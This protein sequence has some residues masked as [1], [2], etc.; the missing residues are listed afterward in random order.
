MVS[1]SSDRLSNKKIAI[2]GNLAGVAND[3]VAGLRAAGIHADLFIHQSDVE[4]TLSDPIARDPIRIE[5][6]FP[7][8]G[9]LTPLNG[10]SAWKIQIMRQFRFQPVR[11]LFG[12]D[13]LHVHSGILNASWL[14]YYFFVHQHQRPYLAFATGSDLREVARFN[15]DRKG[16]RMRLFFRNARRTL[17]LNVDMLDFYH[18]IQTQ[19]ARFFPFVIHEE[20]FSPRQVVKP[21]KYRHKLLCLMISRLDFGI[22]DHA[23]QRQPASI[24]YND[25]FFYALAESVKTN[26]NIHAIVIDRGSDARI[27]RQLV[28][29]LHLTNYV[30]FVPPMNEQQR[31]HYIRMADV[32]IDQFESGAFG[33]GGLE[34]MSCGKPL[35]TY[36]NEKLLHQTYSERPPILNAN[37]VTEIARR[38]SEAQSESRRNEISAQARE[39]I[40]RHH[41]RKAVIPQL[42]QLYSEVLSET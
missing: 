25:R 35:I 28:N 40:V 41:S 1:Q 13:L 11:R 7:L 42:I 14:T 31:L 26:K 22:T 17:L 34:S 39:W 37:T 18:E 30:T 20:K 8:D 19:Q 12:Y 38:L 5:W 2:L 33:L 6:V 24:K 36:F 10:E 4:N 16:R 29:D 27:A 3:I 9:A 15:N 32:V 21:E 23:P